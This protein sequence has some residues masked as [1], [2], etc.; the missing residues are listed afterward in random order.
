MTPSEQQALSQKY[1]ARPVA[2]VPTPDGLAVF[3]CRGADRELL[4]IAPDAQ[5]LWDLLTAEFS[6]AQAARE[7]ALAQ[8]AAKARAAPVLDL[9]LDFSL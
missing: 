7:A 6:Q 4:A 3:R 1:T 8:E 9:D 2:C 5:A